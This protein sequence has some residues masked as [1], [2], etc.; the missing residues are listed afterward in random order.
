MG[1]CTEARLFAAGY[2]AL[3]VL[4][5]LVGYSLNE[6]I[7][8]MLAIRQMSD[9]CAGVIRTLG[10]EAAGCLEAVVSDEASTAQDAG[11]EH[12]ALLAQVDEATAD[13]RGAITDFSIAV[14][15]NTA[16][17][18][19]PILAGFDRVT[20]RVVDLDGM[21]VLRAWMPPVA[22]RVEALGI[23]AHE[24]DKE[25][26]AQWEERLL[27]GWNREM[28]QNSPQG[29]VA[30]SSP[31]SQWARAK[32]EIE[33]PLS[34]SRRLVSRAGLF[35]SGCRSIGDRGA[36]PSG[37]LGG[38]LNGRHRLRKVALRARSSRCTINTPPA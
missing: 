19:A 23:A 1:K 10:A 28:R 24:P 37:F 9:G 30:A 27:E 22:E 35:T 4:T 13:W 33:T 29:T 17:R 26:T 15:K 3:R 25:L 36:N 16:R 8:R 14:C 31:Q 18:A 6:Y 2:D 32:A 21:T 7:G 20:R 38:I 5:Y 11:D 12:R 34:S